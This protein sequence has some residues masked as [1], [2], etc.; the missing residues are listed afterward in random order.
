MT[1]ADKL[2]DIQNI[3]KLYLEYYLS[4]MHISKREHQMLNSFYMVFEQKRVLAVCAHNHHITLNIH[5]VLFF[6]S[7]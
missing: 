7:P 5:P 4:T 1:S 6:K 3:I 2:T